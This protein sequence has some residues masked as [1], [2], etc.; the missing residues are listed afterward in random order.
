MAAA[1][2]HALDALRAIRDR[3][4]FRYT[5]EAGPAFRALARLIAGRAREG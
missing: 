3:G 1:Y 5:A 2:G 4:D